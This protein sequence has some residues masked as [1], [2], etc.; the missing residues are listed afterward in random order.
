MEYRIAN[1]GDREGLISLWQRVFKDERETVELFFENAVRTENAF[2]CADGERIISVVYIFPAKIIDGDKQLKAGYIYAAATDEAYRRKGIMSALL[3]LAA[4]M[5]GQRGYDLLFLRPAEDYL[6][7]YYKKQGYKTVLCTYPM[8]EIGERVPDF[9][10]VC[11]CRGLEKVDSLLCEELSVSFDEG[12]AVYRREGETAKV[13]YFNSEQPD[14]LFE[15]MKNE[16]Q[17][18]II[19][20]PIPSEKSKAKKTGMI[21]PLN[22]EVE[23]LDNIYLGITLE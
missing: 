12:Y 5:A 11:Q 4:D 10:R 18:K 21:L 16:L 22:T 23:A 1:T 13:L 20:A 17:L 3:K 6:F 2:I 9:P 14:R 8:T 19:Y 7:D 15:K